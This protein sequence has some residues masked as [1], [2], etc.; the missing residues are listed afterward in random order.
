VD[1]VEVNT[2]LDPGSNTPMLASFDM[3]ALE[4]DVY[5]VRARF[6]SNLIT[7]SDNVEITR[8]GYEPPVEPAYTLVLEYQISPANITDIDSF[9]IN[10]T[11]SR[12]DG[13][14]MEGIGIGAM[15]GN[16]SVHASIGTGDNGTF[17][18]FFDPVPA[19]V[20]NVTLRSMAGVLES[21][22]TFI[23]SVQETV[24]GDDDDDDDIVDDDVVDDD[25]VDDDT[26]DDD[27]VDDDVV[28]DDTTDDDIVD[29]DIVDDDVKQTN[30]G[31]IAGII[32]GIVFLVLVLIF[33]VLMVRRSQEEV[34]DW[35]DE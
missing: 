12:S 9:W 1:R 35:D 23:L 26:T 27:I 19:S 32:V 16:G 30:W 4:G 18:L 14:K 2:T 29:D 10:G 31:L 22:E 15:I 28:D 6:Q 24:P 20:Y 7:V 8:S 34:M 25:V 13:L 5:F 17:G 11:V 33:I 21:T 3:A